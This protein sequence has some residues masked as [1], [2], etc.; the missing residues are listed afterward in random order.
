MGAP[1]IGEVYEW[2]DGSAR[3]CTGIGERSYSY[4]FGSVLVA[5]ESWNFEPCRPALWYQESPDAL[6]HAE[7]VA[8]EAV[9]ADAKGSLPE[10]HPRKECLGIETCAACISLVEETDRLRLLSRSM[11]AND[12]LRA[13]AQQE[14]TIL[15][16]ALANAQRVASEANERARK[17]EAKLEAITAAMREDDED[18]VPL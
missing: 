3:I 12:R 1:R 4:E 9:I 5:K 16:D 11:D 8:D 7:T 14:V 17:A 6:S 13:M 2:V 15:W 10:P 18:E